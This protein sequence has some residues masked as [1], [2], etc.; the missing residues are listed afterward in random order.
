LGWTLLHSLWQLAA[1]WA[2]ISLLLVVLR[3]GSAHA[4]YIAACAALAATFAAPIV[5]YSIGYGGDPVVEPVAD[6]VPRGDGAEMSL[7]TAPTGPVVDIPVVVADGLAPV[8]DPIDVQPA[9]PTRAPIVVS[10][11]PT[12]SLVDRCR[13]AVSPWTPWL[14]VTWL[15]GV[16]FLSVWNLGGWFVARRLQF[17]GTTPASAELAAR[18]R[19]LVDRTRVTVPV[20]LLV[21]SLTQVPVVIGWFR[22]II[23]LPVVCVSGL[24][25]QQIDA[26]LAHELAHIRRYDYL[27]NLLQT[28]V[29]TFLFFHPVVWWISRRIR[30]ERE[31][32]CDD[33]AVAV[34]GSRV[35]YAEALASLEQQRAAIGPA[36]AARDRRDSTALSRVRRILGVARDEGVCRARVLG[37]VFSA[38][39]LVAL[40]AGY[41]AV[42]GQ[43]ERE[44]GETSAAESTTVDTD[45]EEIAPIGDEGDSTGSSDGHV[46]AGLVTDESG[47][48]IAG[49]RVE[50][51]YYDDPP[52]KRQ[53]TTTN[54]RG[55]YRLAVDKFGVGFRLGVSAKGKAPTWQVY[56]PPW[57]HPSEPVRDEDAVPPERAD[58][59]LEPPCW[60]AGV[61]VDAK[62]KPIKGAKIEAQ[63]AVEGFYSSFSS[64]SSPSPI[65]GDGPFETVTDREGRFRLDGLPSNQVQ[66]SVGAPYRH[67]N[68]R[69]YVVNHQC[70]IAMSGSGRRGVI[71]AR[72]LHAETGK[73]VQD[74]KVARRYD[75][76]QRPF[77]SRDGRFTWDGKFTE[78]KRYSMQ[79]YAKGY[80]PAVVGIPAVPP[81]SE[82]ETTIDLSPSEPLVGGLFDA[83]TGRPMAGVSIMYGVVGDTRYFEWSDLA[84][85]IDGHHGLSLVQRAVVGSDGKFWFGEAKGNEQGTLFVMAPGYER[86][87]LKPEER[88]IDPDSGQ[89]RIALHRE[90]SI[91]GAFLKDGRPQ[92]G[93]EVAVWKKHAR[94][95]LEEF[96]EGAETD[97]DGTYRFGNLAPGTYN[98]A[99]AERVSRSTMTFNTFQSVTLLRGQQ[100]VIEPVA[101]EAGAVAPVEDDNNTSAETPPSEP[102][103]WS[104]ECAACPCKLV[105]RGPTDGLT[106]SKHVV[107]KSWI[108]CAPWVRRPCRLWLRRFKIPTSR[109][110]VTSPWC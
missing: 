89:L 97:S 86:L 110:A 46:I 17:L 9:S 19:T 81:D 93:V 2:V 109:C 99:Y 100:K 62:G 16:V 73:P 88:Q 30:A 12:Q 21:S 8:V 1:I 28:V 10:S 35:E 82:N 40:F 65:P 105:V 14:A 6:R 56:W 50:W 22:P 83:D 79:V 59:Q 55:E 23:L 104:N 32:C 67:V 108:V 77:N 63:T 11:L 3:R 27:V 39:V 61:V 94:G 69:N 71:R 75:P 48:P 72:V 92:A 85:Y 20:R 52:E 78:G 80:A 41:V 102:R 36:V 47:K 29:E 101:V 70:R 87:I 37:G 7:A 33:M 49:A 26:I 107:A 106:R 76:N 4:R 38:F 44:T 42:A 24:S 98:V 84:N 34:C 18:M 31:H 103:N 13:S 57:S 60:I 95:E 51:G 74:F 58:F 15:S 66:L 90:A 54:E 68:D 53:R 64:P 5:T 45:A 25:T 43:T 96:L 91:S